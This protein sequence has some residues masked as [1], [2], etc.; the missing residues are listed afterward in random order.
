MSR[1]PQIFASDIERA[2]TAAGFVKQPRTGT[3]H[4]KWARYANGRKY[5]VTVDQ[6]KE[7]FSHVLMKSM[8]TQAGMST[9]QLY[10]LCTKDGAKQGKQG[11]LAWLMELFN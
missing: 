3:S 6:P 5:S 7:P 11:K 4:E 10:E 2:L 8:A 9:N 1:K